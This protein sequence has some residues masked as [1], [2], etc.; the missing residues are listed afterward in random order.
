MNNWDSNISNQT[1]VDEEKTSLQN[2]DIPVLNEENSKAVIK[3][4]E[5]YASEDSNFQ[6]SGNQKNGIYDTVDTQGSQI[7]G[8]NNNEFDAQNTN[9]NHGNQNN[10]NGNDNVEINGPNYDIQNGNSIPKIYRIVSIK[11]I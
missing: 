1:R 6:N 3:D 10:W 5:N 9:F 7:L 8:N 2:S 4:N 11:N